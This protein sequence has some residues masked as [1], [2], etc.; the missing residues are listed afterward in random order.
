MLHRLAAVKVVRELELEEYAA[1]Y[2]SRPRREATL[3]RIKDKIIKV[4]ST[5]G[6]N[7]DT[8]L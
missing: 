8:M 1:Q 5:N 4:A 6:M 2:F 7:F 3:A